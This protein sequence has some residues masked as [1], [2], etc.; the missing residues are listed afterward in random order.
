[1]Q[2]GSF[3]SPEDRSAMVTRALVPGMG[4]KFMAP[5]NNG[6]VK[7]KRFILLDIKDD[8]AAFIVNSE[9]SPFVKA[10]PEMLECQVEIKHKPEMKF[11][12]HDSVIDCFQ[13]WVFSI[14]DV[15]EQ[16]LLHGDWILGEIDDDTR[17]KVC[18]ALRWSR[19]I[20]PADASRYL[21]A[22]GA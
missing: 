18:E 7:E 2:L 8:V 16:L 11:I 21:S 4:F 17:G 14:D 9:I 13:V 15:K 19:A 12:D 6:V 3:F 20:S 10:R 22:L 1:M 5:M